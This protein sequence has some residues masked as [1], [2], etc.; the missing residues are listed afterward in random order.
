MTLAAGTKLGPYEI[1][2]PLGA[3]GMGEVYR[4]Q[5][6]RLDRTVA[7]KILPEAFANDLDRLHRFE[8][9]ARILSTLNHPNLLA[10]Y[11]VGAQDGIHYLVSEYLEGQTLRERMGTTPLP[12]RK[13]TEYALQIANG[14]AAAHDKGIVHRD[15]KPENVFVTREERVKILD[16]G[17]AK[18]ARLSDL[19][20]ETAAMTSPNPT[21]A[22][23]VLGT[24]G[25]MSPE[26]VKGQPADHRS[27]IFSFGAILYEMISG[28]RAFK[29]ESSVETMSAI[30]KEDPPE[31]SESGLHVSPGMERIIRRC[32]EKSPPQRFQSAKDLAFALDTITSSSV[33]A[34]T[35][36]LPAKAS[37]WIKVG[38][39][40]GALAVLAVAALAWR[41]FSAP[42]TAASTA[43]RRVTVA[44]PE[45]EPL[46]L[47]SLAPLAIGRTSI[48]ISPDG[49]RI[50]YV[51]NRNGTPE[52]FV[53]ELDRFESRAL[54]GTEGA[55]DPFFA[56]DGVWVGFFSGTKLKKVSLLGGDPVTLCEA[57]NPYGATWG[58]DGLIVFADSEGS[59]L[60]Q[61][62]SSG[63]TPKVIVTP[64]GGGL[65]TLPSFLPDGSALVFNMATGSLTNPD[66]DQ[67]QVVSLAKGN[68][69]LLLEGGTYPHYAASGHLLFL[70]GGSLFAAPFDLKRL[71]VTG[72]AVPMIDKIRTESGGAGQLGVSSEGTLVYVAGSAMWQGDFVWV[73]RQG[74]AKPVGLPQQVYG[75]FRISPDGRRLAVAV[76]GKTDEVWVYDFGRGSFTRLTPAGYNWGP[77][78]TPD[79][80]RVTYQTMRDQTRSIFSR[81]ADGSGTEERLLAEAT[82]PGSWSPDGKVLAFD[83]APWGHVCL[84]P[85]GS[86]K[87]QAFTT[88]S[89]T[90][91]GG[92]FSRDGKW[93]AYTSDESGRY[94]VY[95]RPYPGPGGQWQISTDG[96]EEPVWSPDGHELFYRRAFKWMT[97][98][99][100]TTP[101]F[102]AEPPRLLFEGPY[103]NVM[104]VSYDVAPDGQHFLMLRGAEEGKTTQLKVVLNWFE[105]LKRSVPGR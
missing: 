62:S 73:D 8:Y 6:T 79:G 20:A 52:L 7:I 80:K 57:R 29:G 77:I 63:G 34:A 66:M 102:S 89:S 72:P 88:S 17:L 60:T 38:A 27:D 100:R 99:F 30:L 3:G 33:S 84:L 1:G 55:F 64:P 25:Y 18:Q 35:P 56:P 45:A 105:E 9:E 70:R 92:S 101:E 68:R 81:A 10:I 91:W 31:M 41:R 54:P 87:P 22:G 39:V 14:L 13:V 2:T 43:V 16:F 40:V 85:E 53:R 86:Q 104:G 67:I 74:M 42:I 78:W 44:L 48:A 49:S 65:L 83:C 93:I 26:Q 36:A 15:L 21:A 71:E 94:E 28:R 103:V 97:V 47:A 50:A 51:G 23:M 46:A 11:D 82:W 59:N 24:V 96:G 75:S 37:R 69:K 61:V 12:Q 90:E 95:V 5:D 76:A 4:A 32:L 98:R 58:P 19:A